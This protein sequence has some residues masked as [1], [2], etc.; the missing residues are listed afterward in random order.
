MTE[1][2]T[3]RTCYSYVRF[4]SKKQAEGD[5]GRRQ[6]DLARSYCDRRGWTL[7][8]AT[9][10][11]LGVSAFRGKNAL[12]GNL[13]E[14]L[15]A[16]EHSSIKAGAVLI[17]ESLDRISRQGIDE[18]FDLIKKILKADILLV[19]LTPEREFDVSATRSLSKGA[20]EIQLIL[21]RAAEESERKSERLLASWRDKQRRVRDGEVQRRPDSNGRATRCLTRRLPAWLCVKDGVIVAV[22]ERAKVVKRIFQLSAKGHGSGRIVGILTAEGVPSF[23]GKGWVKPY[24]ARI[25][26]DRRA[27]GEYQPCH[28]RRP[29]GPPV[30]GYFPP[31]VSEDL[32]LKANAQLALRTPKPGRPGRTINL[33]SGLLHNARQPGDT[34]NAAIRF[35]GRTPTNP[36]GTKQRLLISTAAAQG[37]GQP[38]SFPHDTFERAILT[39]LNE[40]NVA[41]LFPPDDP[42]VIPDSERL[43]AERKDLRNYKQE[44]QEQLESRRDKDKIPAALAAL[45]SL[46]A[47]LVDLDQRYAEARLREVHPPSESWK[48][49]KTL[50]AALDRARDP[51]A[52]RT[53]LKAALRRIIAGMWL[54]VVPR[55]RVRLC[56]VLLMFH[57]DRC[58]NAY[59]SVLIVHRGAGDNGHGRRQPARWYV[60]SF[61]QPKGSR[62]GW[63]GPWDG[64]Y[65]ESEDEAYGYAPHGL[66]SLDLRQPD[67]ADL[68]RESL[69]GYP[70]DILARLL[71][72]GEDMV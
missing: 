21:E 70:Q 61:A 57:G 53:R 28:G 12:V 59:R 9:F 16:V 71:A 36:T 1:K 6:T 49:V 41:V 33:F 68:A 58:A 34:Y 27:L 14:F 20:L 62:P 63:P 55:G 2:E 32:W 40:I 5:S 39:V 51:I 52:A 43:D 23:S 31:V 15:K 69:E 64:P 42:Q 7:S 56:E 54:M 17:V 72:A 60:A 19:T 37:R 44:L 13:G 22:P 35:S 66:H 65:P 8:G 46:E 29:A 26:R 47:Q 24:V 10:S 30:P 11:D 4:S 3:A 67:Q 50:V 25:T 18:G 48:E 45:A 38:F